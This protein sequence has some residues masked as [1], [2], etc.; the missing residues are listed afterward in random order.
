M[1][2]GTGGPGLLPGLTNHM[3]PPNWPRLPQRLS[4][5]AYPH[6]SSALPDQMGGGA[7][8]VP[9][10]TTPEEFPCTHS[11]EGAIVPGNTTPGPQFRTVG[12]EGGA[13]PGAAPPSPRPSSQQVQCPRASASCH[14]AL[15]GHIT[16][17]PLQPLLPGDPF[18]HPRTVSQC[19]WG[20]PLGAHVGLTALQT[21][22]R[23]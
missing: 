22:A 13:R 8:A 2:T 23:P 14:D 7:S 10:L 5:P 9:P 15:G 21:P 18:S 16:M 11:L 6:V 1:H 19:L 20:G 4:L 17:S 12:P 3:T